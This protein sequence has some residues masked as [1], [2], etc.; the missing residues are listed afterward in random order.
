MSLATDS[1]LY[2]ALKLPPVFPGNAVSYH[3][4]SVHSFHFSSNSA[5]RAGSSAKYQLSYGTKMESLAGEAS[6]GEPKIRMSG[7]KYLRNL[8]TVFVR[9]KDSFHQDE[10]VSKISAFPEAASV[11]LPTS[12]TTLEY[13]LHKRSS[14]LDTAEESSIPETEGRQKQLN[15]R[16]GSNALV[17]GRSTS[18]TSYTS[19]GGSIDEAVRKLFHLEPCLYTHQ[20]F[21]KAARI[22]DYVRNDDV[23]IGDAQNT[24]ENSSVMDFENNQE[25]I[26]TLELAFETLKFHK[27]FQEALQKTEFPQDF[28]HLDNHASLVHVILYDVQSRKFQKRTPFV[29]EELQQI[30]N[31]IEEALL[32]RRTR[33]QSFFA[34]I[35]IKHNAAS[36]QDLLPA[37]VRN[38]NRTKSQIAVYMWVN[39]LRTTMEVVLEELEADGFTKLVM[40]E[41]VTGQTGKVFMADSHCSDLLVFPPNLATFLKNTRWVKL[42]QLVEQDK[43]SC[44]A[45]QSVQYLLGTDKDVIHVNVGSGLTTAHLVS[46]LHKKSP[47]SRIW[48][49]GIDSPSKGRKT[50]KNIDFLGATK[51]TKFLLDDFLSVEPE[52]PKLRYVKVILITTNCSKSAITN[53]VQF[54]ITEGE[55]IRILGEL[56]K[57]TSFAKNINSQVSRHEQCLRHALS[58]PRVQAIVYATRSCC[59]VENESLV[60]KA[61]EFAHVTRA[62]KGIPFR[63][64]PPV[65]PFTFEEIDSGRNGIDDRYI[66]FYPSDKSNGCFIAVI[67]REPEDHKDGFRSMFSLTSSRRHLTKTK[68]T[69][70][71]CEE[72]DTKDTDS[73]GKLTKPSKGGHRKLKAAMSTPVMKAGISSK[74]AGHGSPVALGARL[75]QAGLVHKMEQRAKQK[76]SKLEQFTALKHP[77]PFSPVLGSEAA[78]QP[79]RIPS[80]SG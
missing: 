65:L 22:I 19:S 71:T 38:L 31:E 5:S 28:P 70:L 1:S 58:F 23:N 75:Y 61:V 37:A 56:A 47:Q 68:S 26:I 49:F 60:T 20:M 39:Q 25:E 2:T 77:P 66:R 10:D 42:G 32:T 51:N 69:P 8:P 53:P 44:M 80:G 63:V 55:D 21:L 15:N 64:T 13:L 62:T 24:R 43:S 14:R 30:C 45:A 79:I 52:E 16:S 54:L 36:I 48:G 59:P 4:D 72:Q 76:F 12:T 33:L 34:K 67:S 74:L 41:D 40:G 35:R 7:I 73:A 50:M 29:G 3:S 27:L 18:Y 17:K 6:R 57:G 46:L 9:T 11:S 78:N